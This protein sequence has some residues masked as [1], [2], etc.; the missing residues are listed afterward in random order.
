[1]VGSQLA[2][3]VVRYV[4]EVRGLGVDEALLRELSEMTGLV[5]STRGSGKGG[6]GDDS[7]TAT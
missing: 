4:L 3:V 2:G 7:P 6:P 1:M 5:K